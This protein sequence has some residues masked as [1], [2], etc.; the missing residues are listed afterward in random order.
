MVGRVVAIGRSSGG[1]IGAAV[2]SGSAGI[3]G[4]TSVGAAEG[5]G[6]GSG[7]RV[8]PGAPGSVASGRRADGGERDARRKVHRDVHRDVDRRRGKLG[9]RHRRPVPGPAGAH[10]RD[11]RDQDSPHLPPEYPIRSPL[12]PLQVPC[13]VQDASR[14][15][16]RLPGVP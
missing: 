14:R 3:V 4:R 13:T 2:T 1:G 10:E 8:T 7:A 11:D 12:V 15:L 5:M 6:I 9:S 16:T